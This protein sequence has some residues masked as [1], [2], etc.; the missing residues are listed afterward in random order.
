L[1]VPGPAA[2]SELWQKLQSTAV[3]PQTGAG[4]RLVVFFSK[5]QFTFE[6]LPIVG[7]GRWANDVPP[8]YVPT[9]AEVLMLEF[10][11]IMLFESL[12]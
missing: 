5:W 12:E 11:R 1:A 3:S 6:Q 8:L 7:L 9:P 4:V 10:I 2:G